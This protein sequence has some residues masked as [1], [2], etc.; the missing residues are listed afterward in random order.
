MC[1][2]CCRF[3]L[4]RGAVEHFLRHLTHVRAEVSAPT[5]RTFKVSQGLCFLSK[6][7]NQHFDTSAT[8]SSRCQLNCLLSKCFATSNSDYV[9]IMFVPSVSCFY[10]TLVTSNDCYPRPSFPKQFVSSV[11]CKLKTLLKSCACYPMSF[12][13]EPFVSLV[14][15]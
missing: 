1:I 6:I 2:A 5:R 14:S 8:S 4:S 9:K 10:E 13:S 3:H 7:S 15:C 11:S 12:S